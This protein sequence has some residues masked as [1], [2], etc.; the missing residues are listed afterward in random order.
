MCLEYGIEYRPFQI[1]RNIIY[2]LI[3]VLN[4]GWSNETKYHA[5]GCIFGRGDF[6]LAIGCPDADKRSKR[7][8]N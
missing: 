3:I 4:G 7:S 1:Y 8:E 2:L 6:N 5:F